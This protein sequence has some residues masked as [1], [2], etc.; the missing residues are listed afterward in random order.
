MESF[1]DFYWCMKDG[2]EEKFVRAGMPIVTVDAD[3]VS[4]TDGVKVLGFNLIAENED[5]EYRS[6]VF[7]DEE[8]V[9]VP[10]E[11]NRVASTV[12]K[13]ELRR[14][15]DCWPEGIVVT[16]PC[17]SVSMSLA[18]VELC[19]RMFPE[20]VKVMSDA[21][22]TSSDVQ[23]AGASIAAALKLMTSL[24]DL[25]GESDGQVRL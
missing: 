13:D 1:S 7:D 24:F 6:V 10:S 19:I 12:L 23:Q 5:S 17:P 22:S 2:Q 21:L 9:F 11:R 16:A 25:L 18:A 15:R 4:G 8:G 14:W 3:S 20:Q